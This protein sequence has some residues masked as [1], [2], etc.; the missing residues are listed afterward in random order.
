MIKNTTLMDFEDQ[1]DIY[2]DLQLSN[3]YVLYCWYRHVKRLRGYKVPEMEIARPFLNVEGSVRLAKI[4]VILKYEKGWLKENQVIL[5]S[6]GP[7][8]LH[9]NRA[10]GVLN[11]MGLIKVRKLKTNERFKYEFLLTDEGIQYIEEKLNNLININEINA[12]IPYEDKI[13]NLLK[14]ENNDLVDRATHLF[15]IKNNYRII[16]V[17]EFK[18]IQLFDWSVFGD[19]KWRDYHDS[20]MWALF[21]M[22]KHGLFRTMGSKR[23]EFD[24]QKQ[25]DTYYPQL[26]TSLSL[27]RTLHKELPPYIGEN[28][29][30]AKNYIVNLWYILEGINMFHALFKMCPNI[31]DI[32]RICLLTYK[33][34]VEERG[35]QENTTLRKLRES[36][37]RKDLDR[38]VELNLLKNPGKQGKMFSYQ[39][40]A[41]KFVY[42]NDE[43]NLLNPELIR[44]KYQQFHD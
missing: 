4:N 1:V 30:E 11:D 24:D 21:S 31:D 42:Q 28:K 38:L 35:Y 14:L 8:C 43:L 22:E 44:S 34:E 29:I 37:L 13:I 10:I 19:G 17:G 2:N 5:A 33:L 9:Q 27:Q 41:T 39:I 16:R 25:P 12:K 3:L 6:L 32:A 15:A 18:I 40:P 7:I 36:I 20:L 23:I 26:K